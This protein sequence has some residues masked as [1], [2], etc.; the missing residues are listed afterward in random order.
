VAEKYAHLLPMNGSVAVP[1]LGARWLL[2]HRLEKELVTDC[3][4]LAVEALKQ[5]RKG[6]VA[7]DDVK[8]LAAALRA[9]ETSTASA[10]LFFFLVAITLGIYLLWA[11]CLVNCISSDPGS[12]YRLAIKAMDDLCKGPPEP[13]D[14][15]ITQLEPGV[16]EKVDAAL[17][18]IPDENPLKDLCGKIFT[19]LPKQLCVDQKD[20]SHCY[21]DS[22]YEMLLA[23]NLT[24]H[25]LNGS[26]KEDDETLDISWHP[27]VAFGIDVSRT[28]GNVFEINPGIP[29][30]MW[31]KLI[32]KLILFCKCKNPTHTVKRMRS[33]RNEY[34][35]KKLG[36]SFRYN[37]NEWVLE[38]VLARK[39]EKVFR[40]ALDGAV[41][42]R[43]LSDFF[44]VRHSIN[45]EE[46]IFAF[47]HRRISLCFLNFQYI[48]NLLAAATSRDRLKHVKCSKVE[49][50]N[51]NKLS[52]ELALQPRDRKFRPEAV[53]SDPDM[54]SV[55]EEFNR[56]LLGLDATVRKLLLTTSF[57]FVLK[58]DGRGAAELTEE[59]TMLQYLDA[60]A[61]QWSE[62]TEGESGKINGAL[63]QEAE[64]AFRESP[65]LADFLRPIDLS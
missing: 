26:I 40:E 54:E 8:P 13:A 15:E 21:G 56:L 23:M 30:K 29:G 61:Q 64:D 55:V 22:S 4:V 51:I 50:E 46:S 2:F 60:I 31:N 63:L 11:L 14:G 47:V 59:M 43:P 12:F 28:R 9:T 35:I 39:V 27:Y 20:G 17:P 25:S 42:K 38:S 34:I 53:G 48:A 18:F 45:R 6:G 10:I 1:S 65:E 24:E 16:P 62:E 52:R 41:V 36:D 33:E 44:T 49:G 32:H 58:F 7:S 57:E 37:N 5:F 3:H 19:P